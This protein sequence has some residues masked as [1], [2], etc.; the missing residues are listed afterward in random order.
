MYFDALHGN[1]YRRNSLPIYC[2]FSILLADKN[3]S[4]I[5]GLSGYEAFTQDM[6]AKT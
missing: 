4:D 6:N 1:F 3:I 5:K 2:H